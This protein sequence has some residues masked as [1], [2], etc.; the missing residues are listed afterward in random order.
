MCSGGSVGPVG[1]LQVLP[2][3]I[4]HD[5]IANI[6]DLRSGE[7]LD[8]RSCLELSNEVLGERPQQ[9]ADRPLLL[10]TEEAA[11]LVGNALESLS[12]DPDVKQVAVPVGERVES[13]CDLATS[14]LAG[15]ALTT[16]LDVEEPRHHASYGEHAAGVVVH[17]QAARA[18]SAA[19]RGHPFVAERRIEARGGEHWVGH[20]REH[21]LDGATV[22]HWSGDFLKDIAQPGTRLDLAVTTAGDVTDD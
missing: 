16:R 6:D 17:D 7:R 18:Q 8:E 12:D 10:L 9:T 3:V 22:T 15:S 1:L 4:R 5:P 14:V 13:P 11:V 2:L 19:S 20:A 21:R